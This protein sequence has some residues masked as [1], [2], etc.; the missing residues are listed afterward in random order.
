MS[1]VSDSLA[2]KAA[3]IKSLKYLLAEVE[4]DRLTSFGIQ[5][6]LGEPMVMSLNGTAYTRRY[7][8]TLEIYTPPQEK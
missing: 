7:E 5:V 8:L 6:G 2:R 1:Y 4:G 3:A